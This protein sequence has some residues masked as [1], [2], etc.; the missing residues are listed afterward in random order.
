MGS[1]FVV[2][3]YLVLDGGV[4]G[5]ELEGPRIAALEFDQAL[6]DGELTECV[7]L[8][9]LEEQIIRGGVDIFAG[10]EV[11]GKGQVGVS[12]RG[13]A[14]Q[15]GVLVD[16]DDG[17]A[18]F[19]DFSEEHVDDGF[20]CTWGLAVEDVVSLFDDDGMVESLAGSALVEAVVVCPEHEAFDEEDFVDGG[21]AVEFEDDGVLQQ[22]GEVG[23]ALD[24]DDFTHLPVTEGS[25]GAK[26]GGH[27]VGGASGDFHGLDG[28]EEVVH[29]GVDGDGAVVDAV[30]AVELVEGHL[31]EVHDSFADVG[32]VGEDFDEFL[33]PGRRLGPGWWDEWVEAEGGDIAS[34]R[35]DTNFVFGFGS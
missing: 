13:E 21:E 10:F 16:E 18:E 34:D 33:D 2:R 11:E 12:E 28:F 8:F 5:L 1:D 26:G 24:V 29:G 32:C 35:V 17:F 20:A 23:A 19:A 15:A 9:F 4:D 22:F 25:H 7:F 6:A 3:D 27:P 31:E 14:D 30:F